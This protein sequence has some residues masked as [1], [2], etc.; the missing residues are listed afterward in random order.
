MAQTITPTEQSRGVTNFAS[1]TF[2]GDG[3]TI[4]INCGFTPRYVRAVNETDVTIYEKFGGQATANSIKQVTAGTTTKDTGSAIVINTDR[5]V[6]ISS[7][8]AAS[9]KA[10]FFAIFG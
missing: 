1:G 4:T 9:G 8:A 3:T 7:T 6:T 10:F 5:T 2:T